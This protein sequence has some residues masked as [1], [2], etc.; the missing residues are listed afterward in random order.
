MGTT[1]R[2]SLPL[3]VADE[4]DADWKEVKIE[5]AIGDLASWIARYRRLALHSR[6][7]IDHA[8][9]GSYDTPDVSSGGCPNNGA[10]RPLSVTPNRIPWWSREI[11]PQSRIWRTGDGCLQVAGP[12]KEESR[13]KSK[14]E[15][16]L[17]W[18]GYTEFRSHRSMHR[19]GRLRYGR[20]RRW[21]GLCLHRVSTS[22]WW[23][24][25]S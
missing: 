16:A 1:S 6:V 5:Q 9:S 20:A 22:L 7:F 12:K 25:E 17:R 3:I 10:Y 15:L 4:L 13:F 14:D 23:E 19:K 24:G 8:R 18:Q 21:N 11:P 2:T